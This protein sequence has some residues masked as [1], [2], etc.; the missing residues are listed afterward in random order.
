[1]NEVEPDEGI[2]AVHIGCNHYFLEQK[3]VS[4]AC[5]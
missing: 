3:K 2:T 5:A 4:L 1:M